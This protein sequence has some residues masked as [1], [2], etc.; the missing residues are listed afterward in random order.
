MNKFVQAETIFMDVP[1]GLTEIPSNAFKNILGDQNK[2]KILEISGTFI[3]HLGNNAFSQLNNLE[4][5]SILP[6]LKLSSF[7]KT[8]LNSMKSPKNI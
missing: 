2:L 4:V 8:H 1:N 5:L 6:T 3:K 7:L